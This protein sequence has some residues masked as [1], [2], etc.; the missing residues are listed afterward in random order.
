MA[1]EDQRLLPFC[2]RLLTVS[3]CMGHNHLCVRLL[4][5][6]PTRYG[7]QRPARQDRVQSLL[8]ALSEHI[9]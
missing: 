9:N 7:T 4:L 2:V 8:Q 3:K 1:C 5:L 6:V